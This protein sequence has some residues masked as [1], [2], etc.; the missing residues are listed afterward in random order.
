MREK[1]EA[2]LR[3]GLDAIAAVK[4]EQELQEVKAAYLG[5]QGTLTAFMKEVPKLP[6]EERPEMGKAVNAVKVQLSDAVEER[7]SQPFSVTMTRSSMRTP[8]SPS[9]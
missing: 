4:S 3:E 9:R 6:V 1:M 5:K 8:N 7:I 2:V